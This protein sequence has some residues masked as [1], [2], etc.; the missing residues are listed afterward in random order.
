MKVYC[1]SILAVEGTTKS[2]ILGWRSSDEAQAFK[3]A[4]EKLG[5]DVTLK[6]EWKPGQPKEDK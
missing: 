2:V 6:A 3:D 1:G 4:Y 5:F